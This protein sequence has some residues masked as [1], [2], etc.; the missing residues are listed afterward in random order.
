[1]LRDYLELDVFGFF[2]TRDDII[3][4]FWGPF[5]RSQ[6]GLFADVFVPE[7]GGTKTVISHKSTCSSVRADECK[8]G[9]SAYCSRKA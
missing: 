1:M 9:R 7:H 4:N 5:K 8:E 6:R 2:Y 3:P